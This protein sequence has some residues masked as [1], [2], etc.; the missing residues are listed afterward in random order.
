MIVHYINVYGYDNVTDFIN[1]IYFQAGYTNGVNF[2]RKN[3]VITL[4]NLSF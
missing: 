4:V 2:H 1:L 3:N